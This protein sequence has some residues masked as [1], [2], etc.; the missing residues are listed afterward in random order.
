MAELAAWMFDDAQVIARVEPRLGE[1][2]ARDGLRLHDARVVTRAHG[3]GAPAARQLYSV[4]LT[5][6]HDDI[7]WGLLLS[8]LLYAEQSQ[9][10]QPLRRLGIAQPA[11]DLLRRSLAEAESAV[12][13][14]GESPQIERIGQVFSQAATE[15]RFDL[16]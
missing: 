14:I 4:P 16:A 9:L 3:P 13:V 5:A 10:P 6:A 15:L 1:L 2:A 8:H 12:F 7:V 11:V